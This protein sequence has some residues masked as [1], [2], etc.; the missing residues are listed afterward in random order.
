MLLK[1]LKNFFKNKYQLLVLLFF[2]V[3]LLLGIFIYKDYGISW[4][5]GV[6]RTRGEETYNYILTGEW[7]LP[8]VEIGKYHGTAFVALLTI[9]EKIFNFG[10]DLQK[11]YY[12]RHLCN[13]L[14]FYVSVFFFY[15]LNRKIF[16]S[17]KIGLLA[18]FFLILSPRIFADSFYNPKD[19][20]FLS[21]FIISVFT[22]LN[23]LENKTF[24]RATIHAIVCSF[25]IGI[26]ILGIMVPLLTFI[27][28]ILDFIFKKN[29]IKKPISKKLSSIFLFLIATI[30][31][32][33][34]FS[35]ILWENPIHNFIQNFKQMSSFPWDGSVLFLGR[36]VKADSLPWYYSILWIIITTPLMY[37]TL[38]I[39][40][41]INTIY[42]FLNAPLAYYRKSH[43]FL[44]ILVSFLLPIISVIVSKSVLY[45]GWRQL[46][47]VYPL[48]LII[49]IYGLSNIYSFLIKFYKN[50]KWKIVPQILFYFIIIVVISSL[51][52]ISFFM[53]K[54]HP[55]QNVYFN[56]IAGKN[57]RE[58]FELDYWGLSYR[59]A[60]EYILRLDKSESISIKV[61]N[62]PGHLNYI[63]LNSEDQ[64][65]IK[66]VDNI[67]EAKYFLTEYRSH[68][69]NYPYDNEFYSIIVKG[70]KIMTIYYF[71]END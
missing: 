67:D 11:V 21:V 66:F 34:L 71:Q 48:L 2:I 6:N 58:K 14:L 62:H 33:I 57:I 10:N 63:I 27:F 35:P 30:G 42:N 28:F 25:L 52:N 31:F 61:A 70:E 56:F 29:E 54:Y 1:L 24:I 3:F 45:D 32:T 17:W 50:T 55:H 15:L 64:K 7:N 37:T 36:F 44:I 16:G 60:F 13:F 38:F 18:C 4:D 68:P 26:R 19:L 22:L 69:D 46:F 39:I 40:G 47:F 51:A 43:I 5:E 8:Q 49:S 53:I 9:F 20:P 12:F 59:Q 65:R 23:Y 41:C